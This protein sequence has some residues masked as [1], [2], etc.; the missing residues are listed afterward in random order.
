MPSKAFTQAPIPRPGGN[1]P[2]THATASG[3]A[4]KYLARSNRVP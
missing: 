1:L 3:H 2:R 4:G